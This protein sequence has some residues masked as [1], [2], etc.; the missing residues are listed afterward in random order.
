MEMCYDKRIYGSSLEV[1]L[2][3]SGCLDLPAT[4]QVI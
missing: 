4:F 3:I 1:R 2:W